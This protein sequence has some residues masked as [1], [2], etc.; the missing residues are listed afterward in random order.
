MYILAVDLET[1]GL[2]PDYHE[3]TQI[4][5]ILL[6]EHL[7]ELGEFETLVK[8][9]YPERGLEGG[10][11]VFKYTGIN[12][13]DLQGAT[14]LKEAIRNLETFVR[15]QVGFNMKK[16]VVFGQN[17]RFDIGFIEAAYKQFVWKYPFD[18]HGLGLESMYVYHQL[19]KTGEVP[20]DIT[21]KGICK[22]AGVTNL[23]AHNAI[24]DIRATVDAL[25]SLINEK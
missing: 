9:D 17:P 20:A 2:D 23:R 5:A 3:I 7:K 6:D 4:G 19:K 1:T 8:I 14:P 24:A 18:F 16:V 25:R 21:L 15:F 11:D 12:P 13:K 10:F 22:K